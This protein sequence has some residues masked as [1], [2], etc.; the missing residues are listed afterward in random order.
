MAR[1][2]ALADEEYSLGFRLAG[3]DAEVVASPEELRDRLLRLFQE[4]D[5]GVVLFDQEHLGSLPERL[6][7]WVDE[8]NDPILVPIPMLPAGPRRPSGREEY[9]ARM[10]RRV[11]GYQ[12]KIRR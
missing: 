1:I 12:V 8:S 7:R 3:I 5:A 11:I 4:R 2:L 9:L 6:Q 10:L